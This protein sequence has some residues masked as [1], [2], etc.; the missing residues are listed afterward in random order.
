M[1]M[2]G[3]CDLDRTGIDGKVDEGTGQSGGA[4]WSRRDGANASTNRIQRP[5]WLGW[6]H[7]GH[8]MNVIFDAMSQVAYRD[9]IS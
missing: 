6:K 4:C 2:D 9:A 5:T 8:K 1:M 7:V 3:I